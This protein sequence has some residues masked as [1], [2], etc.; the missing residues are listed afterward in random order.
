[1]ALSEDLS[2]FFD[3]FSVPVVFGA[4]TGEGILDMP[5]EIVADGV[6]LSTD[7]SLT[8]LSSVFGAAKFGDT[9]TVSGTS[10]TVR[11]TLLIDDGKLC[12]I[13]LTRT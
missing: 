13:M 7:Y 2:I 4:I 5:S 6:V 3:D 10:Y 11:E 9:I 8:C 1:M 12:T